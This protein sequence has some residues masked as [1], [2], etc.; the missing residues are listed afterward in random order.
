MTEATI[1]RFKRQA[2]NVSSREHFFPKPRMAVMHYRTTA[3][4]RDEM[5]FNYPNGGTIVN[6]FLIAD[7]SVNTVWLADKILSRVLHAQPRET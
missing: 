2:A 4:R 1:A 6:D 7:E 5:R 3:G